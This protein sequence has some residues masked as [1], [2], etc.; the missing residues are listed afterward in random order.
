MRTTR[1]SQITWNHQDYFCW[2]VPESCRHNLVPSA[3]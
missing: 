3:D 1:T 2:V